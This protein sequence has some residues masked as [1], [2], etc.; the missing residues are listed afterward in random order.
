MHRTLVVLPLLLLA[1]VVAVAVP[2]SHK[3]AHP[4]EGLRNGKE[5]GEMCVRLNKTYTLQQARAF[6]TGGCLAI[7]GGNRLGVAKCVKHAMQRVKQ[8]KPNMK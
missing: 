1:A 8:L 6:V 3:P 7:N 5:V 4:T 2:V